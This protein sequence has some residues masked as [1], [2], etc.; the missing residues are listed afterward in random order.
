MNPPTLK[1]WIN[2]IN[3]LPNDK[4]PDTSE[5]TNEMFKHIRLATQHYLWLLVKAYLKLNNI[6]QQ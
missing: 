2:I 3:Q 5:I 4:A 6:S 1:E